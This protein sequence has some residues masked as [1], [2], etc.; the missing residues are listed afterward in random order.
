MCDTLVALSNATADGSVLFAKNTD[1]EPNEA[2]FLTIIPAAEHAADSTLPAGSS[3]VKCTYVE[4]P[5]VAK[6]YAVLLAKPFWIWGTEMGA[7][8][9]GVVI[10]NEAVF[11]KAQS[12]QPGLIGMDFIRLALERAATAD[13]ALKVITSLLERYG[14]GGNCGF[15][16][17]MY[18]DNSYIIADTREA[19][20][21]E[22]AGRQ[23][24][25]EK[26]KDVRSISNILTI[27]GQWDLASADVV[28]FAVD[29]G[30]C[31]DRS[32]FSFKQ[33]YSDFLFTTFGAGA[34][35]H[36]C[37][38]EQLLVNKGKITPKMMMEVLRTHASATTAKWSPG[39]ALTGADVCMHYGSGPVR[40][41]QSVGS[42]VS[43]LLP[44]M[45]THW[46]T[47]T[48]APC[49]GIFKP[50]WLDA[51]L[52]G[53]GPQPTGTYNETC[54]WWRHEIFHRKVLENYQA[55][56]S[57]FVDE[58]DRLE[59]DFLQSAQAYS[60]ASSADRKK[61]SV[62]CFTKSEELLNAWKKQIARAD[63]Q[64]QMKFY[65]AAAWKAINKQ[66]KLPAG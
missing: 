3:Q 52:P 50:V 40:I 12:K 32:K 64:N 13:E 43:H 4:I 61:F 28:N 44:D 57:L 46:L 34:G 10:G 41:D 6:T 53:I 9:R 27:E 38:A 15:T 8:E 60:G 23:W 33:C 66:A 26:V 16:H 29:R 63:I 19:W 18:Y 39:D 14:Q 31:K 25:A 59:D 1:R 5:Q 42:M 51:G 65:Y 11:T 35:R 22:T 58:R 56:S 37:T 24:V 2:H 36:A 48:S 45:Q 20:V 54:L 49:T 47:G 55:Y 30:W 17:E 7:N 21:L 62:T